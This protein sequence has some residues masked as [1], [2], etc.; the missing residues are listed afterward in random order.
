MKDPKYSDPNAKHELNFLELYA[1]N[2]YTENFRVEENKLKTSNSELEFTP[3]Q[4]KVVAEHRYEGMSNPS[5]QSILYVI[6]ADDNC[7]GTIINSYGPTADLEVHE[8]IES[9]PHENKSHYKSILNLD[10]EG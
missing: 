2:G 4:V 10:D 5:D 7:K 1:K 8:F 6:E 3:E 9:I